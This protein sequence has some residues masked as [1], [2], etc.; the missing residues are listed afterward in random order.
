M[1]DFPGFSNPL[2]GFPS[3][4]DNPNNIVKNWNTLGSNGLLKQINQ[5]I[6]NPDSPDFGTHRFVDIEN[7]REG[8]ING[9]DRTNPPPG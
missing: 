5:K 4:F 6:V 8:Q 2:G 9:T 1:S 7:R 3:P